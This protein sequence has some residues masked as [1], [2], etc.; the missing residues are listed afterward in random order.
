MNTN[1]TG[2]KNPAL[3]LYEYVLLQVLFLCNLGCQSTV[4]TGIIRRGM[5]S[6]QLTD[7]GIKDI[8][9]INSLKHLYCSHSAANIWV[10]KLPVLLPR[11][12]QSVSWR[13]ISSTTFRPL[14]I[15]PGLFRVSPSAPPELSSRATAIHTTTDLGSPEH[16]EIFLHHQLS[17]ESLKLSEVTSIHGSS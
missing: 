2:R 3:P 7:Q 13:M 17:H 8:C 9:S 11:F 16:H 4:S 14:L 10:N 6:G 12:F 5:Y 15:T 1:E